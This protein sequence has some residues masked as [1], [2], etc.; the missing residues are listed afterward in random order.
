MSY[1]PVVVFA[2]NRADKLKMCL[3]ALENNSLV[4][5]TDLFI[6]AD[7]AKGVS[8]IDKVEQVRNYIHQ[9]EQDSKFNKV[10]I[11]EQPKNL[12]L[13]NSIIGGV[14]RVISE[15]H[16][17]IVVEDDLIV[18]AD[19]LSYM[20]QALDYYEYMKEYGSISAYTCPLRELEKY[21]KD[22]YVTHKG[23]CLGWGTWYDRW[24][25]VDWAVSDFDSY[26]NDKKRRKDFNSLENGLDHMLVMQQ[27]GEIDSWAVRWCYHLFNYGLLTVY[28]RVN[29]TINIGFDG[30]GI[31]CGNS[32]DDEKIFNGNILDFNKDCRQCS[33][34]FERLP[35]NKFL[36]RKAANYFTKSRKIN[37]FNRI[38]QYLNIV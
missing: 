4:N 5:M 3:E 2:Y 13:A 6:F 21:D 37:F 27:A 12:G 14:S 35:V 38:K 8:D 7:G 28:P 10:T 11:I 19:F 15:Y 32:K 9:Y 36:E 18:S 22:I 25:N 1:V 30:T 34:V 24:K 16:K 29:R 20:N 23:E 31:N 17:V 33:A 26:L